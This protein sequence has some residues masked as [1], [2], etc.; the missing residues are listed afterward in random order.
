[1]DQYKFRKS[2]CEHWIAPVLKSRLAKR[3]VVNYAESNIE[4]GDINDD[5]TTLSGRTRSEEVKNKKAKTERKACRL[6]KKTL[7]PTTGDLRCR[8]DTS[9]QHLPD[10]DKRDGKTKCA[11]HRYVK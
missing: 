10:P 8:L 3:K 1:M 11:L 6:N 7:H 5:N 2:I 4:C 9:L